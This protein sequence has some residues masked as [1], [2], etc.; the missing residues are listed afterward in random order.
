MIEKNTR[1]IQ[2]FNPVTNRYT[3]IDRSE[4][5]VVACKKSK[6]PYKNIPI[7]QEDET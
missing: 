4:G 1:F 7:Y 6:G 2:L 3:K 5:R